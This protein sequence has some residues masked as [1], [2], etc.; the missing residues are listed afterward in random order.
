M[1][2]EG[3][4]IKKVCDSTS[5]HPQGAI[6]GVIKPGVITVEPLTAAHLKGCGMPARTLAAAPHSCCRYLHVIPGC[7]KTKRPNLGDETP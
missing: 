1:I 2:N 3:G 6:G 5:E 4:V 7:R